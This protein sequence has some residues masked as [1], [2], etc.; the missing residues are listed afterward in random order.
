MPPLAA[1]PEPT[2][3]Y[4]TACNDGDELLQGA[5]VYGFPDETEMEKWFGAGGHVLVQCKPKQYAWLQCPSSWPDDQRKAYAVKFGAREEDIV[6]DYQAVWSTENV[7]M[8]IANPVYGVKD[9][10]P[11]DDGQIDSDASKHGFGD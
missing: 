10:A 11:A 5:R 1:E 7:G 8:D 4:A 2:Y 6:Y 3:W 9:K